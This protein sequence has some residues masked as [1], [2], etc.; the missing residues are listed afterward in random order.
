[1]ATTCVRCA[2]EWLCLGSC[3]H[4]DSIAWM[5]WS[6]HLVSVKLRGG[7]DEWVTVQL[8]T[9]IAQQAV[10]DRLRELLQQLEQRERLR[11]VSAAGRFAAI[12]QKRRW[13]G[14]GGVRCAG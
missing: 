5:W 13:A 11:Q 3:T 6:R 9:V 14:R 8:P 2:I 7:G 4:S 12:Q 1:V 10:Y